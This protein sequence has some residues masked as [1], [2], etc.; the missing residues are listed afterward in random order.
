MTGKIISIGG[1]LLAATAFAACNP[2]DDT[3]EAAKAGA[4]A[5]GAPA[6]AASASGLQSCDDVGRLDPA[7]GDSVTTT[8]EIKLT[9]LDEGSSFKVE[10]ISG[11]VTE[12]GIPGEDAMVRV[13]KMVGT[14]PGQIMEEAGVTALVAPTYQDVDGDGEGDLLIVRDVGNVNAVQG[15]WFGSPDG[16]PYRRVGE[17]SGDFGDL[18][19]DG[20]ITVASRSSAS[21]QCVTFYSVAD[22]QL[23]LQAS[24]CIT[25]EDEAGTKTS[26]V[27]EEVDAL[28]P[29]EVNEENRAKFC[30]EPIVANAFK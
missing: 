3:A 23:S 10:L 27:L 29:L 9:G 20:Y 11:T 6:A 28:N 4:A 2:A 1:F 21:T 7:V 30:A 24:A 22:Q 16:A 18:T 12:A 13:T 26:C 25:A 15:V 5:D 8:C 19:A 14:E 17:V